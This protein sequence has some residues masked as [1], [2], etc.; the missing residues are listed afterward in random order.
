[1]E[2]IVAA[3]CGVLLLFIT[4]VPAFAAEGAVPVV[5]IP[6]G[7]ALDAAG[8]PLLP[9]AEAFAE[10]VYAETL[11]AFKNAVYLGAWDAYFTQLTAA[12]APVFAALQPEETGALPGAVLAQTPPAPA[13]GDL[14]TYTFRYDLRC[15]PL[16]SA[17]ALGAYI[18]AVKAAAGSD[19]V[20]LAARGFGC[21]VAAAYLTRFGWEDVSSFV[22]IGSAAA[23]SAFVSEAFSGEWH[24]D[25][26]AFSAFR[27][28]ENRLMEPLTALASLSVANARSFGV[29]DPAARLELGLSASA[30]VPALLRATYARCPGVWALVD[31]ARYE[32]AKNAL[33]GEDPAHAALIAA[34]DAYHYGVQAVFE[35]TLQRMLADGVRIYN[36]A[37][38]G[39]PLPPLTES[40]AAPSDG[41]ITA[42]A[43]TFAAAPVTDEGL[44]PAAHFLLPETTW[45]V[46]N[47]GC[48]AL[49]AGIAPFVLRLAQSETYLS[50]YSDAAD[51][52]FITYHADADTLTG[53]ANAVNEAPG[54][55]IAR[56][57]AG[58]RRAVKVFFVYVRSF[59]IS[60]LKN[61]TEKDLQRWAAINRP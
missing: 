22:M 42:D 38:Y 51:P 53:P 29:I 50:V 10:A 21:C 30:A 60:N 35:D 54:S 27:K 26:A 24:T 49:P 59:L 61:L 37:G 47:L 48:G 7:I 33:L 28:Q 41:L 32:T 44:L 15:D 1:M 11:P 58:F 14:F 55:F 5:Y 46:K 12:A 16:L 57:F 34:A 9:D 17:Q 25:A 6:E 45:C 13:Q 19:Q 20:A 39:V 56:L 4:L 23:G 8:E 40:A 43:Q 52:Q 36:I 2:K 31:A 18:D 3:L